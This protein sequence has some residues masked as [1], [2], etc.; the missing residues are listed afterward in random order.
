M[1]L[2]ETH[3]DDDVLALLALG[4]DAGTP[5]ER[6]H[7]ALCERCAGEVAALSEVVG[8]ARAA[9]TEMVAPGPQVWERIAA[10]LELTPAAPATGAHAA[11]LAGPGPG[12]VVGEPGPVVGE[13]EA[14][15]GT[16]EAV[17]GE[18][19]AVVVPLTRRRR[20][21]WGWIAGAAAAG[22]VI[23][24][25]GVGWVQSRDDRAQTVVATATLEP[26]PGWS[27]KGS[28]TVQVAR[29]GTRTLVVDV[30]EDTAPDGFREVWLLT[31]DVSGLVS[32]GTLAGSSGRFDLPAGLDLDEFSVVDVSQ[33]PFDG[34]PAHSGDSIV[35]GALTA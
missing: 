23:G 28:A 10:E 25:V 24:G 6:A 35:R 9:D 11:P 15:P 3:V 12:P 32:V 13:S 18:P 34:N 20:V 19:D 27:A 29:D 5:D 33:E 8:L 26:L 1:P 4:E 31:P 16:S 21:A 17:V 22:V 14:G 2:D 7:L 30:A